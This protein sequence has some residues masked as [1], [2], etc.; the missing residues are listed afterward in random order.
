MN[1]ISYRNG[2]F[3]RPPFITG[4]LW[5][6]VN[7]SFTYNGDGETC[8]KMPPPQKK[9]DLRGRAVTHL[10]G[11]KEHYLLISQPGPWQSA[12][13]CGPVLTTMVLSVRRTSQAHFF[14][15]FCGCFSLT[16]SICLSAY[17][18]SL[19]LSIPPYLPFPLQKNLT[20]RWTLFVCYSLWIWVLQYGRA[21]DLALARGGLINHKVFL[22]RWIY[23]LYCTKKLRKC[24]REETAIHHPKKGQRGHFTAS[25][26]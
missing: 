20:S 14:F 7:L 18:T 1:Y 8:I 3:Y 11:K 17:D 5:L 22:S 23:R 6:P 26:K 15:F 13:S 21:W 2:T 19:H 9:E 4:K 16:R 24:R 10:S 25:L 12:S